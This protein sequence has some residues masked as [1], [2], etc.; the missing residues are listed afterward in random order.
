M[1]PQEANLIIRMQVALVNEGIGYRDQQPEDAYILRKATMIA[2]QNGFSHHELWDAYLV[3]D[4]EHLDRGCDKGYRHRSEWQALR[5]QQ[6]RR[7]EPIQPS[8]RTVPQVAVDQVAAEL[9][10]ELRV[11]VDN[12]DLV[13]GLRRA[14]AAALRESPITPRWTPSERIIPITVN[15]PVTG[16]AILESDW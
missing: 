12:R 9:Y 4:Q 3:T 8:T 2:I 10:D 11:A 14:A 13:T 1:T 16:T 7:F 5:E 15:F 6:P